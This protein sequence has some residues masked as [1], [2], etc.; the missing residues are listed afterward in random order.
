M[1]FPSAMFWQ[2]SPEAITD[3]RTLRATW[4]N[5]NMWSNLAQD[6]QDRLMCYWLSTG[7]GWPKRLWGVHGDL[8][9]LPGRGAGQGLNQMDPEV[10]STSAILCLWNMKMPWCVD[11]HAQGPS[12]QCWIRWTAGKYECLGSSGQTQCMGKVCCKKMKEKYPVPQST[13]TC[14]HAPNTIP[15]SAFEPLNLTPCTVQKTYKYHIWCQL[16]KIIREIQINVFLI[17]YLK[18]SCM[19]DS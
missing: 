11:A 19:R 15:N 8:Q 4:F 10:L 3:N 5:Q 1:Y 17:S 12:Q 14:T 16:A 7:M 18:F 6:C 9:K 2:Y 13:H